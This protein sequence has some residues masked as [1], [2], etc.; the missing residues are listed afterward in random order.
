MENLLWPYAPLQPPT[1]KYNLEFNK[2]SSYITITIWDGRNKGNLTLA[3]LCHHML[4][5]QN[6]FLP[7]RLKQVRMT[8]GYN[9]LAFPL[10][11]T[12]L[13]T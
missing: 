10:Q 12:V 7:R 1:P 6:Q 9:R 4:K 3:I 2:G 11:R 5:K 8:D 13:G